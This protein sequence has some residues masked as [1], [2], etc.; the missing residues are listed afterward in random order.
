MNNQDLA[1][2]QEADRHMDPPLP[3]YSE[4]DMIDVIDGNIAYSP[5][6]L[7]RSYALYMV[8]RD[9]VGEKEIQEI[10][11]DSIGMYE[12]KLKELTIQRGF[13]V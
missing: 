6:V 3:K 13:A 10:L 7:T 5:P 12:D 2:L 9:M 8:L 4:M 11:S 1:I